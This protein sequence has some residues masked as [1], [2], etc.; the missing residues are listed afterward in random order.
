[1]CFV[2]GVNCEAKYG[3][4]ARH[5]IDSNV[6]N[7]AQKGKNHKALRAYAASSHSIQNVWTTKRYFK[8][9]RDDKFSKALAFKPATPA[10]MHQ[11]QPDLRHAD[12]STTLVEMILRNYCA[13][14]RAMNAIEGF[15]CSLHEF[16]QR[17]ELPLLQRP[18]NY[19]TQ[20]LRQST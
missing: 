11:R 12:S 7:R 1:M 6:H 9:A 19:T 20:Y 5:I 8:P 3:R 15:P 18:T 16:V 4:K 13:D 10:S 2:S 17:G 14:T